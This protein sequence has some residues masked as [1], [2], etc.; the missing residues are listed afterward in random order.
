M[1]ISVCADCFSTSHTFAMIIT[2]FLEYCNKNNGSM[3]IERK[4]EV[5]N[6]VDILRRLD[7]CPAASS[8]IS[9]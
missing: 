2:R 3:A 9:E 5:E 4:D 8:G 7:L 6:I 1:D